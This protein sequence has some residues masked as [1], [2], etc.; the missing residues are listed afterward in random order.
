MLYAERGEKAKG[1][2]NRGF[3]SWGKGEK[4]QLRQSWEKNGDTSLLRR[5]RDAR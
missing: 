4:V 1:R 3:N 2:Q 5:K